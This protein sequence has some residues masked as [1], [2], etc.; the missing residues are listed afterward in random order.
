MADRLQGKVALITGGMSG[1]GEA[2]ARLFACEGARVAITGRRVELG[3][4][5]VAQINRA[6]AEAIFTA[7]DVTR[8]RIVSDRLLERLPLSDASTFSSTMRV[9]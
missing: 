5:I 3:Q 9:S 2:T 1:L 7:A 6:G 4:A 8:V